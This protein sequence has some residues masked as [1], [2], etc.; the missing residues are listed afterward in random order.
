MAVPV[1]ELPDSPLELARLIDAATAKLGESA[2]GLAADSEVLEIAMMLESARRRSD[3]VCGSVLMEVS[4]RELFRVSGHT[5]VKRFYAQELRLGAAEAKR[6]LEVAEAI[7]PATAM[8]G[9]KLPP[10]REALADAVVEG[11]VSAE[12]VHEVELIMAKVPRAASVEE[13]ETAVQILAQAAR[14]MAPAELRP[15]G[16]RLIAH[17]DPDG[18]LSDDTDRRRQ[19]SVTIGR[20]DNQ[21]LSKLTGVLT[22][23]LRAKIEVILNAWAAPGVNNPDDEDPNPITNP[24]HLDGDASSQEH[25]EKLAEAGRRDT[26]SAAQRNHDALEAMCDWILRH[27]G[28]GRPTRIPSQLVI[29]I[30]EQ[31][32]AR[33][34]GVALTAT[35]TMVPTA[36]LIELAADAVPWLEVFRDATRVVLDFARGRRL[37]TMAQRLAMF[38]QDLGCTRPGCTEPFCR[39]QA[40]HATADF[41]QGG[42]TNLGDMGSA[43]GPDNRNVG[44][45]AGQWE[46][47]IITDGPDAGRTGWR[48]AGS[49][50]PYRTNP[51]HDPRALLDKQRQSGNPTATEPDPPGEPAGRD[52][53]AGPDE[54]TMR[55]RIRPAPDEPLDDQPSPVERALNAL[56]FAA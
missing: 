28:L 17:L 36:E 21:L 32:L 48:L 29:T 26:R 43:C 34:A 18:E 38:G 6:R 2:L 12:H 13:V 53:P 1:I 27:Q 39:T 5:T 22:P 52:Q 33:R 35:G 23:A 24:H 50:G 55:R 16:Q 51:V 47:T 37:A 7:I 4:D 42:Q 20:Q 14:E 44:T 19:R 30:D 8:T 49:T 15:I 25:R 11:V 40:H 45:K 9:Q 46:T 41:A 54:P 3:G 31:D 10:K 56:L